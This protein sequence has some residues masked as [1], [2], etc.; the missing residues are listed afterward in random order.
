MSR[1]LGQSIIR[2]LSLVLLVICSTTITIHSQTQE[3]SRPVVAFEGNKIFSSTELEAEVNKCI[4]PYSNEKFSTVLEYCVDQLKVFVMSR[5]YLQAK[6]SA[7]NADQLDEQSK[8]VVTVKEGPLYRVGEIR[9][10]AAHLF[11]P[12]QIREV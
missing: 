6:L 3:K 4:D 12:D 8:L 2:I 5:G 9:I 10:D 11:S 7:P 1:N